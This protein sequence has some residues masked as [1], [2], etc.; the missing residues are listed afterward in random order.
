MVIQ[1][2]LPSERIL[3]VGRALQDQIILL[4]SR[5]FKVKEVFEDPQG[6][7]AAVK[8]SITEIIFD[9]LGTGVHFAIVDNKTQ[10]LKDIIRSIIN[11]L[12]Y[13]LPILLMKGLVCFAVNRMNCRRTTGLNENRAHMIAFIGRRVNFKKEFKCGLADYVEAYDPKVRSNAVDQLRGEACI[14]LYPS[15]NVCGSWIL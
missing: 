5:G 9:I 1:S 15:G 6:S 10:R 11:A 12:P 4:S 14:A 13:K 2:T 3:S 7:V 8:Y